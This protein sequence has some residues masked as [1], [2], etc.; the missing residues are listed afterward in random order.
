MT[1]TSLQPAT[2]K[3]PLRARQL[4]PPPANLDLLNFGGQAEKHVVVC[5]ASVPAEEHQFVAGVFVE[6]PA[7]P[8]RQQQM[9]FAMK[10]EVYRTAQQ[11][12]EILLKATGEMVLQKFLSA[13]VELKLAATLMYAGECVTVKKRLVDW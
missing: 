1:K 13:I 5:P 7:G 12:L 8:G 9:E 2:I 3:F 4:T 6:H 10:T 11:A